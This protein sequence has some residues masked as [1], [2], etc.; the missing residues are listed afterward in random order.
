MQYSTKQK[1]VWPRAVLHIDADAFFA[2]VEEVLN[3]RLKGKPVIVGGSS[4]RRGV[5]SSAN[6]LARQYGVRSAMSMREALRLCP[7]GIVVCSGFKHYK[8]FSRRMFEIFGRFTPMVQPTSVDEGYLDLSGTEMMHGKSMREVAKEILCTVNNELGISVSGGLATNK[9]I[10]KIASG[11]N[12]PHALTTVTP[13]KEA[14]FLAPLPVEKMPGIGPKTKSALYTY[15]FTKLGDIARLS[16][17]EAYQKLG[18]SGVGL[19]KKARGVDNRDVHVDCGPPKSISKERTFSSDHSNKDFLTNVLKKLSNEVLFS[20]RKKRLMAHVINL[21]IRYSD[22]KTY[23]IS[24]TLLGPSDS[25]FEIYPL[26]K[27]LFLERLD[28]NRRVRLVGFG[29]SDLRSEYNLSLFSGIQND[30]TKVIHLGDVLRKKY[31]MKIV[32][33]GLDG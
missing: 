25:D 15:G 3:P 23:T 28:P 27:T 18:R 16:F 19:W 1:V 10:A 9:T 13:G 26:A 33:Y 4:M 6:Y 31:G 14:M 5:V 24:K 8:S 12:K 11:L 21:K 32:S 29:V 30:Q 20:L 7:K 22:F 17:E 2:S